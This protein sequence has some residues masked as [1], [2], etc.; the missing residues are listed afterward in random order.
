MY[1]QEFNEYYTLILSIDKFL[2]CW[3]GYS[4]SMELQQLFFF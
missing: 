3:D 2:E 4:T 1:N